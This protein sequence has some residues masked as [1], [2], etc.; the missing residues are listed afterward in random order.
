MHKLEPPTIF[1]EV[2]KNVHAS[3]RHPIDIHLEKD[4]ITSSVFDQKVERHGPIE[5]FQTVAVIVIG[6]GNSILFCRLADRVEFVSLLLVS[7]EV[8]LRLCGRKN[9]TPG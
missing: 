7:V 2:L 1:L 9:N 5:F 3:R 6:E 8:R 4:E